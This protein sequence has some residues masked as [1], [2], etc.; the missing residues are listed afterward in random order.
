MSNRL[1]VQPLTAKQLFDAYRSSPRGPVLPAHEMYFNKNGAQLHR[2]QQAG[3]MPVSTSSSKPST[4]IFT[5]LVFF[6]MLLDMYRR[7]SLGHRRCWL[8]S[9]RRRRPLHVAHLVNVG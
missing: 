4:S 8:Q 7:A 6:P 3:P 5:T 1:R 9:P 2:G